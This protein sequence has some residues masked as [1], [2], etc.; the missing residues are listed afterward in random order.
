MVCRL[1]QRLCRGLSRSLLAPTR[2][3]PP[4]PCVALGPCRGG[5]GLLA[6]RH[7]SHR[8][9]PRLVVVGIDQHEAKVAVESTSTLQSPL[10]VHIDSYTSLLA[11]LR[12]ACSDYLIRVSS[13][14]AH[15]CIRY[16]Y[17]TP[18]R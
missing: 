14:S 5:R 13:I 6:S 4:P 2:T 10:L 16:R 17:S 11:L 18:T 9:Q 7:C 12:L 8:Y 15:K 3:S 1:Q